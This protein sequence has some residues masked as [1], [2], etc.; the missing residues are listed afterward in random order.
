MVSL[1]GHTPFVAKLGLG[2]AKAMKEGFTR[3]DFFKIGALIG[4]GYALPRVI[5]D[6]ICKPKEDGLPPLNAESFVPTICRQCPALCLQKI[7][8]VSGKPVGVEGM[9]GHPLNQGALCSKGLAVLQEFYHPDRL[10][11]PLKR[12]G[13]RGSGD[14]E[15]ISWTA[16]ANLVRSQMVSIERN[17]G[18]FGIFSGSF[19]LQGKVMEKFARAFGTPNFW[20][21]H[22]EPSEPPLDAFRNPR[23][24]PEKISYDFNSADLIVSFGWDWLQ[25]MDSPVEVQRLFSELRRGRQGHRTRFL[26]LESQLSIS[27]AKSDEWFPILPGREGVAAL[28]VAHVLIS[29]GLYDK[30]LSERRVK[31]FDSFKRMVL[32]EY[33]PDR[34]EKDCGMRAED[35][36]RIARAM[37]SVKRSLAITWRS[38]LFNQEA[39]NSLNLLT[40]NSDLIHE[41]RDFNGAFSLSKATHSEKT[42]LADIK[43]WPK[44]FLNASRSPIEVLL[45]DGFNPAFTGP[46]PSAWKEALGKIP[47][48]ASF[49]PFMDETSSLADLILPPPVSIESW[50]G[51]VAES[52]DGTAF[53]NFAPPAVQ[54]LHDTKDAADFALGIARAMGGRMASLLPW[55]SFEEALRGVAKGY[56]AGKDLK[57]GGWRKIAPPVHGASLQ[58]SLE[59]LKTSDGGDLFEADKSGYPLKLCVQFP[60]CFS[61]GEGA[62]LP[63]LQSLPGPQIGEQWETWAAIHPQTA[64]R[65]GIEDRQMVWVSS[66]SG[67]I[68]ARAR[69][70]EKMDTHTVSIPFGLG[71]SEMGRWAAGVGSN[72]AEIVAIEASSGKPRWQGQGVN[73]HV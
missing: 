42:P 8:L 72:P 53:F 29:E 25:Q 13:P 40:D 71:H 65:L 5:G 51:G 23:G 62:H 21:P 61:R 48:I 1:L 3:R 39:V 10:T 43:K 28:C 9:P 66:S 64:S 50:Q 68:R 37:G 30:G 46:D 55:G 58:A 70:Y 18:A 32:K 52:L 11:G 15:K 19:G 56:G 67:R 14:W 54:P 60:L 33:P 35:I 44:F 36:R 17:P 49:S 12:R 6:E 69:L 7:R 38:S 2:E 45:I 73:I 57:K 22:W 20:R 27:A 41:I 47:F 34:A 63:Y 4:A 24:V 26:H 59:N 31:G 16:A